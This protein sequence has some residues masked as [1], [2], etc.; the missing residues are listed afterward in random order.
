[1]N[2]TKASLDSSQII[3]DQNYSLIQILSN[4]REEPIRSY[5]LD[6]LQCTVCGKSRYDALFMIVHRVGLIARKREVPG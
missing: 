2:Q 5:N 3:I 6:P 1:M 4:C